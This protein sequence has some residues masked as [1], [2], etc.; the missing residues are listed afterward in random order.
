MS[1]PDPRFCVCRHHADGHADKCYGPDCACLVFED[2]RLVAAAR[3]RAV[4]IL[5]ALSNRPANEPNGF[6][7]SS[8]PSPQEPSPGP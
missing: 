8:S 2:V 4:L 3:R 1:H 5:H 6:P 7:S